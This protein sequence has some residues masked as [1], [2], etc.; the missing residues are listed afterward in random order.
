MYGVLIVD[1]EVSI[2]RLIKYLIPWE[3][4][5][6]RLVDVVYN[7][8]AAMDII[9][10]GQVDILITDAKM[11]GC[12]GIELIKWCRE[13]DMPVKS[14]VI[15]GFRQFEYAHGAIRYG[16]DAYIL[17][18]INQDE[19]VE[20]LKKIIEEK[21]S[22]E[23]TKQMQKLLDKNRGSLK[24]YF[25]D[26]Y[27]KPEPGKMATVLKD[28]QAVNEKYQTNFV[29]GIFRMLYFKLIYENSMGAD[30]DT[31]LDVVK[32]TV[33][34]F[35]DAYGCEHIE[36]R[37]RRGICCFVNYPRE[38]EGAF[39]T[40]LETLYRQLSGRLEVYASVRLIIGIGQ[41]QTQIT[42]ISMCRQ[43]AIEAAAYRIR[44]PMKPLL[45]YDAYT[46]VP[47]DMG[48]IFTKELQELTKKSLMDG[49]L[50]GL[51]DIL[52]QCRGNFRQI[53]DYS[54]AAVF[55][56][57]ENF[58]ETVLGELRDLSLVEPMGEN[59]IR[60]R[61]VEASDAAAGENELWRALDSFAQEIIHLFESTRDSGQNRPVQLARQYIDAHFCEAMSLDDVAEAV[62]L[63][64]RYLSRV[65]RQEA[66]LNY[67]DYVTAK[68]MEYASELLRKTTMSVADIA[69]KTGYQDVK[70]FTKLFRRKMGIRPSEYRRIYS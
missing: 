53:A 23:S 43:T 27:L 63:N 16:A 57:I 41:A 34:E 68:R 5:G 22:A 17:K 4:L 66:G 58:A 28:P 14:I 31:L 30:T 25:G 54:P 11:P 2:C 26:T 69:I 67:L 18:P 56:F 36:S 19:L 42:H 35:Y 50:N 62:H 6:L 15:S 12:D 61:L 7:G 40:A 21:G 55:T 44:H 20:A 70:Y 49:S 8:F 33:D 24:T 46:Y 37:Y 3:S 59:A 60:E 64:P 48:R 9:R 13:N 51:K 32:N 38:D 52:F 45:E 47:V 1:D 29:D 65:F 10:S 39:M